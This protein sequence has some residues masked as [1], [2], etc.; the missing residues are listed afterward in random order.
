[1][2]M[3]WLVGQP[4]AHRLVHGPVRN[5]MVVVEHKQ[6]GCAH[7]CPDEADFFLIA[8][9]E[10]ADERGDDV[11]LVVEDPAVVEAD[12]GS[13]G[14]AQPEGIDYRFDTVAG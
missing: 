7:E 3:G 2:N 11:A 4:E 5:Q 1:M 14:Q 8:E 9:R 12:P 6:A 13:Q 10:V